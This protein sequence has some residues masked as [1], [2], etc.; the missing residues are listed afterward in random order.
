MM[1]LKQEDVHKALHVDNTKK[2]SVKYEQASAANTMSAQEQKMMQWRSRVVEYTNAKDP[3]NPNTLEDCEDL[4]R[5]L[6]RWYDATFAKCYEDN[7]DGYRLLAKTVSEL[8]PECERKFTKDPPQFV[9]AGGLGGDDGYCTALNNLYSS[10]LDVEGE[11]KET[12]NSLQQQFPGS[13]VIFAPAAKAVA[14]VIEKATAKQ[15][16][17]ADK[18]LGLK[19]IKDVLRGTIVMQDFAQIAQCMVMLAKGYNG[20]ELVRVKNKFAAEE[21]EI[22]HP[23]EGRIKDKNPNFC[24]IDGKHNKNKQNLFVQLTGGPKGDKFFRRLQVYR[25]VLDDETG[26]AKQEDPEGRGV[27]CNLPYG[28][29]TPASKDLEYYGA[30]MWYYWNPEPSTAS[31]CEGQPK[32]YSTLYVN[33]WVHDGGDEEKGWRDILLNLRFPNTNE[34][35]CELQLHLQPMLN[36]RE[37]GV[38]DEEAWCMKKKN[39]EWPVVSHNGKRERANGHIVYEAKREHFGR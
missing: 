21:S 34:H 11:Y 31:G 38:P 1:G 32:G 24:L 5:D 7:A 18:I 14:G 15:G 27:D 10:A 37:E 29:T 36:I 6:N 12:V 28:A 3:G 16:P 17:G 30:G 39:K 4:E 9:D 20:V 8:V 13:R 2:L 25:K 35:V 26:R 19:V 22:G 33:S 23:T